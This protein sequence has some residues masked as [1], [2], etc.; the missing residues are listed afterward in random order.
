[1]TKHVH[2]LT[3]VMEHGRILVAS[4]R[5]PAFDETGNF[6]LGSIALHWRRFS[7]ASVMATYGNTRAMCCRASSRLL[8][9]RDTWRRCIS[10][11]VLSRPRP[12]RQIWIYFW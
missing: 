3:P 2:C 11:A 12:P 1:G 10:L 7:P 5:L 4:S 8:G 6:L 9:A